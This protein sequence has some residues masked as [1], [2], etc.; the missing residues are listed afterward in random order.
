MNIVISQ[1]KNAFIVAYHFDSSHLIAHF[2]IVSV[3][4]KSSSVYIT[5]IYDQSMSDCTV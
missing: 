2:S 5:L 3:P 4:C 1:R